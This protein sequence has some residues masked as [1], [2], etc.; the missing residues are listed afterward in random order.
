M[1]V[2][3]RKPGERL[4][5][6]VPGGDRIII[7]LIDPRYDKARIGVEAPR[8]YVVVREEIARPKSN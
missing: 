4:F 6:D 3:T 7:T 1:L 8:D 5:I 2:L